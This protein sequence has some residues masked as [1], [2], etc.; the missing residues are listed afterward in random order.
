[1]RADS[2][3]DPVALPTEPVGNSGSVDH[4]T[5]PFREQVDE[6]IL[7]RAAELFAQH[8]FAQTSLKALAEAV[9]LS[10][11]GLLH[12]YPSKEAIHEA[13]LDMGRAQ[14]RRV[15]DD[16]SRLPAGPGR[17]MR[18]LELLT[19]V[20]LER[21]GLVSLALRP[22]TVPG[23]I[24]EALDV[25]DVLIHE[26]FAIDPA[27]QGSER[28]IRVIGALSSLAV[29][30]LTANHHGDKTTWRPR[31]IATCFD[32]LGHSRTGTSSPG[33]DQLED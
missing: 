8:G 13:A 26:M 3:T 19:D 27:D 21:A 28:L 10:K 7:D 24:E 30:S 18:A 6:E 22:I 5:R 14:A 25:D 1:M 4:V 29:L 17:D 15:L 12:H 23:E 9:G 11:A 20:A 32:A 2:Q 16:V 33:S 31:I